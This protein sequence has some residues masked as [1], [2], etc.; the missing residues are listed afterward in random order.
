MK[1]F[2]SILLPLLT[3]VPTF[4]AEDREGGGTSTPNCPAWRPCIIDS[5]FSSVC[6][7]S[8]GLTDSAERLACIDL[9]Y[10]CAATKTQ[11]APRNGSPPLL[12]PGGTANELYEGL[13]LLAAVP[14]VSESGRFCLVEMVPSLSSGPH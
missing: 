3:A 9:G 2:L 6:T 8:A 4:D 7:D 5:H 10:T 12:T 14:V 11:P 13:R 1:L